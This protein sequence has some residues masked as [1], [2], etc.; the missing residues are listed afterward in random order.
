MVCSTSGRTCGGNSHL[1]LHVSCMP[2]EATLGGG[3]SGECTE[4]SSLTPLQKK[5][6]P[7]MTLLHYFDKLFFFSIEGTAEAFP[8]GKK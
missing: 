7:I 6:T 1:N 3:G 5:R 4:P 8:S 2:V